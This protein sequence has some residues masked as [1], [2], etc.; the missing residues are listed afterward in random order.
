MALSRSE[1]ELS[2]QE[3]EISLVIRGVAKPARGS[4]FPLMQMREYMKVL[5]PSI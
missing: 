3:K 2:E 5:L 4:N 1:N